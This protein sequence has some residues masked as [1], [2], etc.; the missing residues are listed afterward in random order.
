LTEPSSSVS[1]HDEDGQAR[2]GV[3]ARYEKEPLKNDPQDDESGDDANA[4]GKGA[5]K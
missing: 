3:L 4:A 5:K 2:Q 1:V